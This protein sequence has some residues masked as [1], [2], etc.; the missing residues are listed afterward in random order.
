VTTSPARSTLIC[1]RLV[2]GCA[3]PSGLR[4]CRC[5]TQLWVTTLML[6]LVES[7][8]LTPV[9]APCGTQEG[10]RIEIHPRTMEE[11]IRRDQVDEAWQIVNVLNA[12]VP[13]SHSADVAD[14][15]SGSES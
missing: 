2:D 3:A 10:R 7:G 1:N 14:H 12:E 4:A 13:G 6:P 15:H 5:G 8:E 11:L 9:C